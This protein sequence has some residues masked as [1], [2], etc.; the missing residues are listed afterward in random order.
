[1]TD[2]HDVEL[3]DSPL[4]GEL[5]RDGVTVKVAIYRIRDSG[6]GWSLEVIDH[7]GTSTVW[8][9]TFPTDQDAYREFNRSLETEGIRAL[10]QGNPSRELH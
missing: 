9:A 1:M 4:S 6:E 10:L 8:D 2:D 5:T 7:Q 3:E